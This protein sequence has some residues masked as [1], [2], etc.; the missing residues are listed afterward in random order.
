[1]DAFSSEFLPA[2][3][4]CEDSTKRMVSKQASTRVYIVRR[5]LHTIG[6]QLNDLGG[7]QQM[8][9]NPRCDDARSE[10]CRSKEDTDVPR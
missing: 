9:P 3:A 8:T 1:M 10:E 2:G 7:N 4:L 6:C 5:E